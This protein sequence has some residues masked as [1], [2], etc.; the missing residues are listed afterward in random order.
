MPIGFADHTHTDRVYSFSQVHSS[1]TDK[2]DVENE[3]MNLQ[4]PKEAD[5]SGLFASVTKKITSFL[6]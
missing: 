2:D 1:D 5:D 6:A 4:A 3:D